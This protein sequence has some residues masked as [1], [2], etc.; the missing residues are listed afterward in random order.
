MM[1]GQCARRA[2]HGMRR[3][4]RRRAGHASAPCRLRQGSAGDETSDTAARRFPT[5]RRGELAFCHGMVRRMLV[6]GDSG[7]GLGPPDGLSR[8]GELPRCRALQVHRLPHVHRRVRRL[9]SNRSRCACGG[10]SV[11]ARREG[12]IPAVPNVLGG[13]CRDRL[14]PG[15]DFRSGRTRP[16]YRST[17]TQGA[18][19]SILETAGE[20]NRAP[21]PKGR[22]AWGSRLIRI[23]PLGRGQHRDCAGAATAR[24]NRGLLHCE[25]RTL[26]PAWTLGLDQRT[27]ASLPPIPAG[28]RR[29]TM[30]R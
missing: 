23:G 4:R 27:S 22:L 18:V 28:K 20:K 16:R 14:R 21:Q 12:M 2:S 29:M 13:T 10:W 8:H 5:R 19:V 7:P 30:C 15:C 6:V 1:S 26:H 17:K 9:P 3:R 11:G 25:W 24:A